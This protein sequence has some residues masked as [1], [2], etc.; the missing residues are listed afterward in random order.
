MNSTNVTL[1][2]HEAIAYA[3]RFGGDLN[4]YADPVDGAR[5]VDIDEAREIARED[6]SLIWVDAPAWDPTR[7]T[8]THAAVGNDGRRPCVWGLGTSAEMAFADALQQD[9]LEAADGVFLR[10]MEVGPEVQERVQHGD[11]TWSWA[12]A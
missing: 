3:A 9:G 1:T 5:V 6:A 2:G 7:M 4:K 10:L 12:N 8:A 11:V